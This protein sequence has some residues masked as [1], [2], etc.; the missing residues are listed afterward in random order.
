VTLDD[1][2]LAKKKKRSGLIASLLLP[3]TRLDQVHPRSLGRIRAEWSS[4]GL[5]PAPSSPRSW[6]ATYIYQPKG[7]WNAGTKQQAADSNVAHALERT[8]DQGTGTLERPG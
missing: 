3:A 1:G 4:E 7:W 6:D 8:G 2:P 5:L